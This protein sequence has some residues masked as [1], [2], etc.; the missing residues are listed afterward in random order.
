VK[1]HP[2]E[3]LTGEE[4]SGEESSAKIFSNE[5]FGEECSANPFFEET[6]PFLARQVNFVNLLKQISLNFYSLDFFCNF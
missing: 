4:S 1:N 6:N 2:S 5:L 3:E